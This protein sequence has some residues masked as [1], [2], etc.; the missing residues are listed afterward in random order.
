MSIEINDHL[1]RRYDLFAEVLLNAV[2]RGMSA[3]SAVSDANEA[4]KGLDFAFGVEI[5]FV[6]EPKSGELEFEGHQ[7]DTLTEFYPAGC[8]HYYEE[9]AIWV[10]QNKLAN[11]SAN[12][13]AQ[14]F[15]ENKIPTVTGVDWTVRNVQNFITRWL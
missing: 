15:L 5:E 10:R 12:R 6:E 2:K 1:I 14:T 3:K 13:L 9:L 11:L 4:V 8:R 7:F